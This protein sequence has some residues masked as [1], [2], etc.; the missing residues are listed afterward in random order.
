MRT[1]RLRDLFLPWGGLALGTVGFFTAQQIGSDWT[2]EDCTVGS[3][4]VVVVG[5]GIG[6]ALIAIGAVAS[7]R[8]FGAEREQS[9]RR[10]I[11]AVSLMSA[12]LFALAVLLPVVAALVIPRCWA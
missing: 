7:W 2:F 11:A 8:A 4:W 6:L 1:T 10:M 3:P 5:M 9:A 12:A